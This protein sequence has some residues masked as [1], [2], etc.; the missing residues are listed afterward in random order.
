MPPVGAAFWW[1]APLKKA[2]VDADGHLRPG[3][4]SGNDA[5]KGDPIPD[6]TAGL[7]PVFPSPGGD[8]PGP[9]SP[10]KATSRG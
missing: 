10:S 6:S 8:K 9:P 5:M 2:V 4:W 1:H 7:R 3:Y